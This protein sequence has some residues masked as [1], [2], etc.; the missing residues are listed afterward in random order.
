MSSWFHSL[1][2][3]AWKDGDDETQGRD[4]THTVKLSDAYYNFKEGD[5]YRNMSKKEKH[6]VDAAPGEFASDRSLLPPRPAQSWL[7]TRKK[8][9]K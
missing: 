3:I 8:L 1:Y 5:V 6:W 7:T 4:M 2:E 9:G